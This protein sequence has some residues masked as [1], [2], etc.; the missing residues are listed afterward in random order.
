MFYQFEV[1]SLTS[2]ISSVGLM[3]ISGI[4]PGIHIDKFKNAFWA[5]IVIG[6]LNI[7]IAPILFFLTLP[8][9][10]LTLGLFSFVLN[11]MILK[12]ASVI[13]KGFIIENWIS[14]LIGAT[15]LTI[16]Q[17][18]I[19]SLFDFSWAVSKV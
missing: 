15:F 1:W 9:T 7:S 11:A 10:I 3:I 2:L 16:F 19:L 6:I 8:I 13:V 12:L 4:V 5:S 14:A 17:V 18:L